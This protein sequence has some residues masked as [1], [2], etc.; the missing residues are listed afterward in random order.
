MNK[1][2]NLCHCARGP[3]SQKPASS[4][5]CKRLCTRPAAKRRPR[6][7]RLARSPHPGRSMGLGRESFPPPG[8]ILA[9]VTADCSW[10]LI[11]LGRHP[12]AGRTPRAGKTR[13]RRRALQTLDHFLSSPFLSVHRTAAAKAAGG[14]PR[15]RGPPPFADGCEEQRRPHMAAA[16]PPAHGQ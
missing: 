11:C 5:S 4:P 6:P 7:A 16:L 10:P 1:T 3:A 15:H 2:L 8:L 9:R 12:T 13:G 14:A